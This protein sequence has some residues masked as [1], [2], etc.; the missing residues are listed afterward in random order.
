MFN[1]KV[2]NKFIKYDDVRFKE[3]EKLVLQME[4]KIIFERL[5]IQY[6]EDQQLKEERKERKIAE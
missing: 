4:Y 2:K 6:Q 3:A 1:C 5:Q